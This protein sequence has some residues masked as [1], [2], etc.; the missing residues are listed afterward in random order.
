MA[1][2]CKSL[3]SGLA[4]LLLLLLAACAVGPD[5]KRP[6][7]PAIERFT[8]DPLPAFTAAARG[9]GGAA[10]RLDLG[11]DI[12]GEWWTLF[13]SPALDALIKEA[14]R[15][16][17]TITA[18][19]AALRQAH[20]LTLAGQGAFFPLVQAEFNASRNK[21][22]GVLGPTPQ[23]NALYYNLYTPQLSVSYT[24]D[25]FGGTRRT[26]EALAAQEENQRFQLEAAYLTLTSGL[27]AAVI[28][29]AE[30]RD[31]I[32][33]T[34]K[35]IAIERESLDILRRQLAFGQVADADVAA[36]RA[37]L[38][39]AQ[40]TL[41]PLQ[42][43]VAQERDLIA[44][45]VGRYPRQAPETRFDLA[46]LR[47]PPDVPLSLPSRLV[48][49]RPD[50]RAAAADLHAASAEIGVAIANM[51]PDVSLSANVGS[52]ALTLASLFGPGAGFWTV[53][54]DATQ[55]VFDAGTNVHKTRAAKAAFDQAAAQ[56]K[57]TVITA[58]QNVADSLE[59]LK[60]DAD[61]LSAAVA[62]EAAA[63]IS[64]DIARRQLALGAVSYLAILQAEQ[65]YE[66]ALIN[67]VQAE[68]ARFA[69]TTALFQ[70]LGGGW[71]NRTDV[72]PAE[73]ARSVLSLPAALLP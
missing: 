56:Y 66:Q 44:A 12:P 65:T 16:S 38:A 9:P 53:V 24:P 35:I 43:Q 11:R 20:E 49:Q 48:E 27:V 22:P 46:S 4:T 33:A 41:P 39:Q 30:L 70:A 67:R 51:L 7:P 72:P 58:F 50:I 10:Q 59:A 13:R 36:Q 18:A 63:K 5:F 21:T 32:A 64:L 23:S 17:P 57:E 1:G 42:K 62:A 52:S 37:A 6:P 69:D 55:T 15:R 34:E 31:Q 25:V 68:A 73:T 54:A 71:W 45:L 8:A 26:V 19:V 28:G 29:E 60:S 2:A 61:A 14:L 40:A 47:L 3:Q